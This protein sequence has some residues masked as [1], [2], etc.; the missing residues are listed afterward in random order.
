MSLFVKNTVFLFRIVKHLFLFSCLAFRVHANL[1][2]RTV[3][4]IC[5]YEIQTK[6]MHRFIL[7]IML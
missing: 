7:F 3:L 1:L 5:F 2:Q 4:S 6:K